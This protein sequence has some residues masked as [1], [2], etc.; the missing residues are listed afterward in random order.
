[1]SLASLLSLRGWQLRLVKIENE[2]LVRGATAAVLSG[3]DGSQRHWM[4][5]R[6]EHLWKICLNKRAGVV[7]VRVGSDRCCVKLYYDDRPRT[8]LRTLL[9]RT[10]AL[11]AYRNGRMLRCYGI[12]CPHMIGYAEAR[13]WGPSLLVSE[14]VD[15]AVPCDRFLAEQGPNGPLV[16]QFAGFIRK[17]HD[18]GVA[19]VDLQLR[20][21]LVRPR[22][23]V[24]GTGA[25]ARNYEFL[26]V[27]LED[28]RVHRGLSHRVRAGNLHRLN[29]WAMTTVPVKWR[30]RFLKHYL[31]GDGV[32]SWARELKRMVFT[33]P[34]EDRAITI[35]SGA[36]FTEHA[37][38][39]PAPR[40]RAA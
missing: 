34:P 1:M 17:M 8:K 39:S 26:L 19:H 22:S 37:G 18:A 16:R 23:V 3:Y 20:N 36:L 40:K 21:V 11:R 27:D 24:G 4:P 5:E 25:A 6:S 7:G 14:L 29:K 33:H 28:V 2:E 9:G 15:D 13:P 38:Q 12:R 10:R 31:R 35:R 30:L 32:R